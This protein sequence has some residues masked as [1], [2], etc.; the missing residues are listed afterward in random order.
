MITLR[1]R[2]I[3]T[4]VATFAVAA[5]VTAQ[6]A[7]SYQK[8]PMFPRPCIG[9]HVS[10]R[11]VNFWSAVTVVIGCECRRMTEHG[12]YCAHRTK[13]LKELYN[14]KVQVV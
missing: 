8:G 10:A 1:R 11:Q 5:P 9:R 13:I 6:S 4:V 2:L 7:G 3:A 12:R 14:D